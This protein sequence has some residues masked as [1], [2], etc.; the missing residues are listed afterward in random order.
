MISSRCQ[1]I[2]H[3]KS[4]KK[5]AKNDLKFLRYEFHMLT[6]LKSH[7]DADHE[8]HDMAP[9]IRNEFKTHGHR[10]K[11]KSEFK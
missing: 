10:P 4:I 7:K 8:E 2:D 6:K 9:N 11:I 1:H 5:N 3:Q